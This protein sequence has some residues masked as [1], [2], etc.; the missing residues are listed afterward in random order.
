V[1][2][3]LE[4][5]MFTEKDGDNNVKREEKNKSESPSTLLIEMNKLLYFEKNVPCTGGAFG[6]MCH[7]KYGE[8]AR[9]HG[10]HESVIHGPYIRGRRKFF[11]FVYFLN[12]MNKS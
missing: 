7:L 10:W 11:E 3:G 2:N 6:E 5:D 8:D 9:R 4:N 12:F 1:K